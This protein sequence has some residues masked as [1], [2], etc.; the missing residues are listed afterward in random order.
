MRFG[1]LT[2]SLGLAASFLVMAC[3]GPEAAPEE[4]AIGEPRHAEAPPLCDTSYSYAYY[5]DAT[6]TTRVGTRQCHCGA[7]P[8]RTGTI[9]AFEKVIRPEMECGF[10]AR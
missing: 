9:T 8:V 2:R 4:Q 7:P 5:S 3:G 10:N 6:L 1:Q